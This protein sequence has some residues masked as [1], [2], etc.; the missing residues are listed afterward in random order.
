M[1]GFRRS[2]DGFLVSYRDPH[3]KNT[4]KIFS[5]T[6]AFIRSFQ[7]DEREMTK[8]I[9]GTI[10]ELDVPMNPSTKGAMSLN[11]YFGKLTEEDILTER[12]EILNAS[13]EDIQ[14][15]GDIVEAIMNQNIIC[16]IGGEGK[17]EENKELF[18]EVKPLF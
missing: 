16:V 5:E 4:L 13:V 1:S 15:L 12:E 10:S 3:L 8:Y 2:G 17:I 7:A 9:I 18:K 6:P 11:A 14:R